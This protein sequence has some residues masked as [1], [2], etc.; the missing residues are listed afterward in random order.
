MLT[1][2]ISDA[3]P[4]TSPPFSTSL[5]NRILPCMHRQPIRE[6]ERGGSL[7]VSIR[8][9]KNK[10]ASKKGGREHHQK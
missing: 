2:M 1:I 6:R 4:G 10:K 3:N 5:G 7:F 9:P 8:S